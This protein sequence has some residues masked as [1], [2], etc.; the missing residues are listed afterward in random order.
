MIIFPTIELREGRCVQLRQGDPNAETAICENPV[1]LALRWVKQGAEWLHIVNLDGA[2]GT[3]KAHI[4]ALYR[5]SNILIKHPGSAEPESP[6]VDLMRRLPIN[7]QQLRAIR[8]AVDIPIQFGG[9]LR[10]LDDIRLALELGV[11]RV[12]LG[13]MAVENPDLVRAAVEQWGNKRIAVGIDVRNGKVA[14]HGWQKLNDVDPIDLAHCA[15]ALGIRRIVYTDISRDGTLSGVNIN[16]AARMGD[17][18][19]LRVIV[20]GGV[21]DLYDVRRLKEREHFNI[22]G[23]IIGRALTEPTLE[24]AEAVEV[25]H[26]QLKRS[27]AGI[28]PFRQVEGRVE[29]L[30]LFNLF[31]EQWQFPRGGVDGEECNQACAMR[32]F[33]EETGLRV[34]Q[35]HDDCHTTLEY[36]TMIR[37]YEIERKIV[38]YLAEVTS[39]EVQLAHENHCE[40]RWMDAQEAWELLTETA[41]EQLPAL[42]AAVAYLQETVA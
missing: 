39:H 24:L 33:E 21:A 38:Y 30:L 34:T 28:V 22:E 27:S 18:T 36:T 7:L 40:A 25:G 15:Y 41:P 2:L 29:F 16:E 12:I 17:L 5:P 20:R 10:T 14:T 3:T 13:T 19:S 31:F 23:I 9:G 4:N 11:D 35:M 26:Q 42:D 8:K 32:E 1:E 6:E 37:D